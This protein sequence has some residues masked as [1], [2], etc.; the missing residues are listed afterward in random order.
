MCLV[1]VVIPAYNVEAYI[2]RTVNSVL[3]QTLSDLEVI[4]VNDGS[5][6]STLDVLSLMTNPKLKVVNQTNSG[7]SVARNTG[8]AAAT[9]KYV[10]FLDGDDWL[11]AEALADMCR[12]SERN[13]LDMLLS[14]FYLDNDGGIV[15]Y[16]K[17]NEMKTADY[18]QETLLGHVAPS[19]CGKLY[20]RTLF[21]QNDILFPAGLSIGEDLY[22]S[23]KLAYFSKK[24]EKI[25]QA[26]VHY[27]QR[28]ESLTTSYTE[29][30][31]DIFKAMALIQQFLK[32][33]DQYEEYAEKFVFT[34][35]L[36]TYFFRINKHPRRGKEIHH[37]IYLMGKGK[38]KEYDQN[39]YV[40]H[41][42][43]QLN[44]IS[45]MTERLYRMNYHLGFAFK[46]IIH[47]LRR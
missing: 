6:D 35:F 18:L 34:T 8:L 15:K 13:G 26:Y 31:Y 24:V 39:H 19:V 46:G 36:H 2:K 10:F 29:K 12:I 16:V 44:L 42:L 4:V 9:G 33:H 28:K 41:Y 32:Q 23:V 21:T 45:R 5:Q 27:I 7:V 47:V 17:R 37:A 22:V 43:S 20:L 1:S 14:D 3:N 38:Y 11:E 25:E 40:R 30:M